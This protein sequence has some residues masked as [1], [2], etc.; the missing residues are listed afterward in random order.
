[1]SMRNCLACAY[2]HDWDY[3]NG[4]TELTAVA[5]F[6]SSQGKDGRRVATF[7]MQSMPMGIWAPTWCPLRDDTSAQA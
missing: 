3:S 1:M 7:D 5:C 4:Y 6:H 2:G